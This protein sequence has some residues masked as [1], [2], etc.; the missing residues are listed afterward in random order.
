MVIQKPVDWVDS[1]WKAGPR[2]LS[3]CKT[4]SGSRATLW[5]VILDAD[6]WTRLIAGGL[7][8]GIIHLLESRTQR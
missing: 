4:R 5:T 2:A 8:Q 3:V 7:Q 6:A 1:L